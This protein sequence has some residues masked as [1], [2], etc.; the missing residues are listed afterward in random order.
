MGSTGLPPWVA[1]SLLW[2]CYKHVGLGFL[3]H[4]L[5]QYHG[6]YP[7]FVWG[8]VLRGTQGYDS[9][10]LASDPQNSLGSG[11]SDVVLPYP[12]L[13]ILG[14]SEGASPPHHVS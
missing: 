14:R 10:V 11:P 7:P 5:V 6:I 1:H 13:Q 3:V 9:V 8:W 12:R 2:A 4:W